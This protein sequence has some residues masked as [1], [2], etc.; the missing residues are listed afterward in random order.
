[1]PV[2]LQQEATGS[3]QQQAEIQCTRCA[4]QDPIQP[5]GAL[6][7]VQSFQV[8]RPPA[9]GHKVEAE[10]GHQRHDDVGAHDAGDDRRG[11]HHHHAVHERLAPLPVPASALARGHGQRRNDQ[12]NATAQRMHRQHCPEACILWFHVRG[13]VPRRT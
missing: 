6:A 1:M 3:I 8:Q 12:R 9:A 7:F 4:V 5:L 2:M 13:F 10:H 11:T